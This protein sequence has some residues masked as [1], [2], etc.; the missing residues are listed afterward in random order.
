MSVLSAVSPPNIL[1]NKQPSRKRLVHSS[2]DSL[3]GTVTLV[4]GVTTS[5]SL[6][7]CVG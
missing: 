3:N 4:A 2:G 6:I 1:M 5:R 7:Y